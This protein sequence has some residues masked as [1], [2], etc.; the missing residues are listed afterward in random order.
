[1]SGLLLRSSLRHLGRHPLL[2]GLSVIGIALGVAVVVA[3]D[4]A[5]GSARRAFD[6]SNESVNGR[7]THQVVGATP[8]SLVDGIYVTL[9]RDLGIATAAPVVEGYATR[10]AGPPGR[11]L[12]VFGV[13]PFAE[14][15]FRTFGGAGSGSGLGG[16]VDVA[17]LLTRPGAALVSPPLAREL[18]LR[19]GSDGTL[20]V[21]GVRRP[22]FIAG[23]LSAGGRSGGSGADAALARAALDDVVITD[24]STAEEWL[25]QPGRLTRIDVILPTGPA[26][27]A[28]RTRIARACGD[29]CSLVPVAARAGAAAQMTRAFTLNLQ[30]MSFLALLVG[31]FL[32]YNTMTFSVVQRRPL[33][34]TLRA[35]GVTRGELFAL[36]LGEAILLALPATAL[37]LGLGIGLG[38]ELVRLV[39]RTINDLYFVV[40]V[41]SLDL[42]GFTLGKGVVLGLGA[43][44]LAALAPAREATRIAPTL[45]LRRS[46]AEARLARQAGWLALGGGGLGAAALLLLAGSGRSLA[47]AYVGLFSVLA[48]AALT[49]PF[50]TRAFARLARLP[51]TRAFGITGTLAARG[52]VASLTRT[53]VALAALTIAVATTVGVGIM[54]ESFRGTVVSWLGTTLQA[55]IFVGPPSLVSRRGDG[56][57]E[58]EVATRLAATTGVLAVNTIR[59]RRVRT[60]TSTATGGPPTGEVDL[61]VPTFG[62]STLPRPYRFSSRLTEDVAGALR[63]PDAIAISEPYAFHQRLAVGSTLGLATDRGPRTLRVVAVYADYASDEGGI[64]MARPT[65]ERLFDDRGISALS[66]VA[67]PGTDLEL[68]RGRL[69]AAAGGAQSLVIRQSRELRDASIAIF[70][71]TFLI[72]RVLRTLSVGVA[73]VGVLSALMALALERARELAVLRALGLVPRQLAWIVTLQTSLMGLCAGLL[74]LP[75]GVALAL[76]LV[77][78]INRRSFG[79]TLALEVSPRVL[80][81]AVA[82]SLGAAWLAGLYPAWKMSR[83][84]PA[85]ALRDE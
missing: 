64:M 43:T 54:V 25:G 61:H 55:D 67:A 75:L 45:T 36:V 57:L 72:T 3:I 53:S 83:A 60:T 33:L 50:A 37:G 80:A 13:D 71:R 66:I 46:F 23:L 48:G 44:V 84:N 28:A 26:G 4:L 19:P 77:H 5:S 62:D 7:T 49:T 47:L 73:F 2:T 8:E 30:A 69:A 79:W 6:L 39:T 82:L 29:A 40:N 41:R 35:L 14:G 1:M 38:T 32:I 59:N 9:R 56:T 52:I 20:L 10:G 12:R 11:A 68:L 34:G 22:L 51:M 63:A 24:V 17:T 74:S 65:Y 81:E 18:G 58:P 31:M 42:D 15:P 85:R 76:I 21:N 70:D 16:G 78:V 27:D